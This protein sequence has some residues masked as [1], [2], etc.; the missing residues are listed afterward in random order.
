[1]FYLFETPFFLDI[2]AF[3]VFHKVSEQRVFLRH[4]INWFYAHLN[5]HL[6]VWPSQSQKQSLFHQGWIKS[7]QQTTQ[8]FG[9]NSSEAIPK[10]GK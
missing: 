4:I 2:C 3:K 6:G 8:Q 5:L 9:C 1:M 10:Y 7:K